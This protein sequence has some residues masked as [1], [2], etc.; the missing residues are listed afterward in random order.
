MA[1]YNPNLA[2]IN[3]SYTFEE[4]AVIFGVHKNTVAC[5]VR[6]GLHCLKDKRPYLILG[7]DAKAYLRQRRSCN[8]QRC[9]PNEMYCMRCKSP[10]R[11]AGNVVE[12]WR[13]SETKGRIT[14]FCSSC[15][16]RVN[17]FVADHNFETYESLFKLSSSQDVKHISDCNNP[18]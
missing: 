18:L 6:D 14:G 8:K 11:P 5:W 7:T 17:K 9:Q 4:L 12:Y 2:K 15:G 1:N 3:R 13:L 16:A 10:A